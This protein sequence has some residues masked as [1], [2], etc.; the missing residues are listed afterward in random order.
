MIKPML[1]QVYDSEKFTIELH[2]NVMV[3]P[4]LDGI[5]CIFTKD[6]AYSRAG[7]K[8]MNLAHLE[9]KLIPFFKKNPEIILDGELYNH[10]LKDNFE[11]IV[12]LVKK[13]KPTADD[14]LDAQNLVQYY[15]YD[16]VPAKPSM[17]QVY[18]A[19]YDYIHKEFKKKKYAKIIQV[20]PTYPVL[21]AEEA[22]TYHQAFLAEG[23]E[24]SIIRAN[25]LYKQKRSPYLLKVKDFSDT[26]ATITGYEEGK[27]KRQGT[28]GKFLMTD[29]EGVEFGCPPGKGYTY[30]DLSNMLLNIHYYMGKRATFTYFQ[31]TK[32]GSY[33]HPLFK[34]LRNYE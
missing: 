14:R 16:I 17:N 29:D 7:N 1:A 28:L 11:K 5:R 22:R 21:N 3:Q 13:K 9:L 34:S 24:G 23:Y 6:G 26:E 33:R 25:Q 30:K 10:K 27:G 19:R 2:E 20:T 12:S 4:K 15:V 32:K 8:F 18:T 31:R